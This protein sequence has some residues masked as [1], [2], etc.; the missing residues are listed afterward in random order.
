[1]I[2]KIGDADFSGLI[3]GL[4]VGYETLVSDSS[5]RN[6][7]GDSVIDIINTKRKLYV[8]LKYTFADEMERFLD[9]I[10]PFTV[11]VSFMD[12]RSHQLTT[13]DAYIGTP[14]PEY[15]S[16]NESNPNKSIYKPL[17]LNFIEL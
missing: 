17:S 4:K 7:N 10:E 1:M 6:A 8:T 15:Y 16:I 9:A 3:S 5:G 12:P 11:E 2:F 13:I 14:E